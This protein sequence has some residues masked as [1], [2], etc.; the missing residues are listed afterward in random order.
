MRPIRAAALAVALTLGGQ[1]VASGT[2]L[3]K[4]TPDI[5]TTDDCFGKF[6]DDGHKCDLDFCLGRV[7]GDNEAAVSLKYSECKQG[8]RQT[9]ADPA[10]PEGCS[11]ETA[12]K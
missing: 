12:T 8:V 3:P 5:V 10:S 4:L 2:A 9:A 7:S 11:E 1:A 6:A